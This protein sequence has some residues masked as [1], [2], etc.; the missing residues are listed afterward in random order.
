M[1]L[2]NL[3]PTGENQKTY[4]TVDTQSS[5][6][7]SYYNRSGGY[8]YRG[9]YTTGTST[10]YDTYY[11]GYT[12]SG[13]YSKVYNGTYYA[14]YYASGVSYAGI[15]YI[16]RYS[17]DWECTAFTDY[18]HKI[19]KTGYKYYSYYYVTAWY[20]YLTQVSAK[21]VYCL[22][23]KYYNVGYSNKITRYYQ[24]WYG[25]Y[26]YAYSLK[27]A[28]PKDSVYT[29]FYY[30]YGY[31]EAASGNGV[32]DANMAIPVDYLLSGYVMPTA[33]YS[34]YYSYYYYT[35]ANYKMYYGYYTYTSST[36]ARYYGYYYYYTGPF[37]DTKYSYT[38]S[39]IDV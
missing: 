9:Y 3:L 17:G 27:N 19:S 18:N 20:Y 35:Y 25:I 28:R 30:N 6:A 26:Y 4:Q 29:Y 12:T 22:D 23:C 8:Y 38:R 16:K 39:Y 34:R 10:L 32:A 7:Y 1:V 36:Y 15:T 37:S 11:R 31:S 13:T 2:T 14:G 21:Q 33:S 5:Q 24:T